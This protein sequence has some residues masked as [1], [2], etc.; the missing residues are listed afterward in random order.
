MYKQITSNKRKSFLLIAFFIIF[1]VFLGWIFGQFTGD[2][3][4]VLI[5]ALIISLTMALISFYSGD[6]VA[7]WTA[8]AKG[9]I[10]K[11]D[12]PYVYRLV[13]NLCITAGLPTPKIYLIPDP[14]PNAFATGRDPK[15]ASIALTTG[16][17]ERLEN[18]ELEG[19]IAHELSHIK[20]YDI[21]LMMI[22]IVLVGIVALLSNWLLR[23]RFLGGR[24]DDREGSGQIGVILLLAGIVLAILS[25]LISKLIQLAVSRKRE[26]LAD[27]DGA[28][29]T[30][31][32]EGLA[33]ALEKIST[34]TGPMARANDA[35]AHLYI[36]NPFGEKK[37]KFFHKLF[38]THP[39]AEER[40]KALRTMA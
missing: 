26:F 30:R 6:K 4:G 13:E 10:Q 20:N 12:N 2:S 31:Y 37:N 11:N 15:H 33:R 5:L 40:I 38:S 3:Y 28:L 16:L 24:R 17:I 21:R 18:E 36:S 19:V 9:P 34:Y 1:V 25:P 7:L 22:V 32:P 8:G 27:A 35:T 14:A 39:P 29:L 23:F